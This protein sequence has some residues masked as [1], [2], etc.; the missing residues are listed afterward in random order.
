MKRGGIFA[1]VTYILYTLLYGGLTLMFYYEVDK[2]KDEEI[3]AA[4]ALIFLVLITLCV[5]LAIGGLVA[6]VLKLLHMVTGWLIF[7]IPCILIDIYSVLSAISA[8]MEMASTGEQYS[9][10]ILIMLIPMVFSVG[11]LISNIKSAIIYCSLNSYLYL[12][13]RN[14]KSF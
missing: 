14:V 8:V 11:A 12:K 3:F 2:L 13:S 5:S 7:G 10:G 9:S 6:V 4:L 1:L